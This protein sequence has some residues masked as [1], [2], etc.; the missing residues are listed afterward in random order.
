MAGESTLYPGTGW[1]LR[2]AR[3]PV[4]AAAPPHLAPKSI[5]RP[6]LAWV[7]AAKGIGIAAVVFVHTTTNVPG[8]KFFL[9]F[10]MPLFFFLSGYLH[11]PQPGGPYARRKAIHLLVPYV[12]FLLFI[13]AL[14]FVH[15]LHH[16]ELNAAVLRRGLLHGLWGGSQLGGMFSVLWFLTC[17]FLTQQ[18]MNWMLLHL[19]LV[20]LIAITL[21]AMFAGDGLSHLFPSFSLPLGANVVLAAMPFFLLGSLSRRWR[22]DGWPSLLFGITCVIAAPVLL[23]RGLPVFYDM[24]NGFYGVPFL[25]FVLSSGCIFTCVQVARASVQVPL[26][27]WVLRNLGVM[28]LGI[29]L[30]HKVVPM[31]PGYSVLPVAGPGTPTLVDL[32]VSWGVAL[33]L[34]RSS[35]TRALFLGCEHDFTTH[36]SPVL[37]HLRPRHQAHAFAR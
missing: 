32:A 18:I 31:I 8:M 35:L 6:H 14:R 37:A 7:D 30:V 13:A 28:S 2:P 4:A 22:L 29:M 20:P 5:A 23:A 21:G 19:R 16:R 36:I 10:A 26:F 9:L 17:L 24:H 11:K 34:S 33:L 15:L 27:G 25:T 12:S 1:P 3:A